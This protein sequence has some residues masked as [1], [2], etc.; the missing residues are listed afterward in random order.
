MLLCL[1]RYIT[2]ANQAMTLTTAEHVHTHFCIFFASLTLAS[3][4]ALNLNPRKTD[5]LKE[6]VF[7]KHEG[8]VLFL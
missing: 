6:I 8:Q 5:Q 4:S 1:H 3:S 7:Q 2:S